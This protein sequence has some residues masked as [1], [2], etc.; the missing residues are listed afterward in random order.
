L[1][2]VLSDT[3]GRRRRQ[4]RTFASGGERGSAKEKIDYLLLSPALQKRVEHVDVF[5]R[6]FYAPRKW[7]AFENITGEN[8]HRFQA[9]DHH[10]VWAQLQA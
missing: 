2:V 7:E 8:K 3:E 1:V 10:C 4:C 6:G 5:R 9:L